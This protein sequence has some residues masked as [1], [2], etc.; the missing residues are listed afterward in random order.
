METRITV[1]YCPLKHTDVVI[2]EDG[3]PGSEPGEIHWQM[4]RCSGL[5]QECFEKGCQHHP[6]MLWQLFHRN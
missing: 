5:D 3:S 1:K 2:V 6:A 4:Q